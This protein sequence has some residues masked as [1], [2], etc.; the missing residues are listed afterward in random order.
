MTI[1]GFKLTTPGKPGVSIIPLGPPLVAA[2]N[3]A[4]RERA[5]VDIWLLA[6]FGSPEDDVHIGSFAPDGSVCA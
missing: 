2:R 4:L 1:S 6:Y 3:M 5:R